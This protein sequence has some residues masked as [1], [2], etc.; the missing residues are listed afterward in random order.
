[1]VT[2]TVLL[3]AAVRLRIHQHGDQARVKAREMV[4]TMR[5]K[6]DEEGADTWLRIIV[7]IGALGTPPTDLRH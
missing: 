3:N 4:E 7:A 1:M 6:A 2:L 5:H